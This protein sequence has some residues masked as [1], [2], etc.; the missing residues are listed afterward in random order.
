MREG[1]KS[2][3]LCV[4]QCFRWRDGGQQKLDMNVCFCVKGRGQRKR[5]NLESYIS[6]C[7]F[8]GEGR[9]D[10]PEIN[11]VFLFVTGEGRKG[12]RKKSLGCEGPEIHM[13][14]FASRR[15]R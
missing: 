15:K 1:Q 12:V 13:L 11:I 2:K 9:K 7:V 10:C 6:L 5:E 4:F 3:Q 8:W 14:Y